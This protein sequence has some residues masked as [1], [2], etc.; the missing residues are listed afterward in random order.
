MHCWCLKENHERQLE[1]TVISRKHIALTVNEELDLHKRLVDNLDQPVEFTGSQIQW[2]E[3][4][5][6]NRSDA[7]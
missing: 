3:L 1:E 7:A 6:S 4:F 5:A 2:L